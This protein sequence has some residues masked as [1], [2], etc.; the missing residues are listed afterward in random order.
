M[1]QL[2]KLMLQLVSDGRWGLSVAG[3]VAAPPPPAASL[4]DGCMNSKSSN[5]T[6]ERL[7]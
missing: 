3:L 1:A 7:D 5:G 6:E 4:Q 2:N